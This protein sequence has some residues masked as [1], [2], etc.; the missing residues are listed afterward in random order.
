MK[1]AAPAVWEANGRCGKIPKTTMFL[2]ANLTTAEVEKRLT[3]AVRSKLTLIH[4][5]EASLSSEHITELCTGAL[6]A[7][8]ALYPFLPSVVGLGKQ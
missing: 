1:V 8:K 4:S 5:G 3:P 2:S 6:Q 7:S